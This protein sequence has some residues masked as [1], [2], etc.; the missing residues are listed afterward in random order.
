MDNP[1]P[2]TRLRE[3]ISPPGEY[4]SNEVKGTAELSEDSFGRTWEAP[5]EWDG[6]RG[7]VEKVQWDGFAMESE[8]KRERKE[9]E[10]RRDAVKRAFGY[11]WQAYKDHAWGESN[12]LLSSELSGLSS[13]LSG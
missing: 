7:R 2:D 1:F 4:V 9:R 10:G 13:D 11:A 12:C 3:I 5:E 8:G 6:P